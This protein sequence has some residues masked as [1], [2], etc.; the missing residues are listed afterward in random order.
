M[1]A[2]EWKEKG[3]AAFG[4]GKVALAADLYSKGIAVDAS[5]RP[6]L[7]PPCS[8]RMKLPLEEL[9]LGGI[10]STWAVESFAS[11]SAFLRFV[12]YAP[13]LLALSWL[14]SV[15]TEQLNKY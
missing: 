10:A 14:S 11:L 6:S 8:N 3:N 15:Q 7:A 2:E 9:F 12:D 4:Q 1:S 5:V 13:L